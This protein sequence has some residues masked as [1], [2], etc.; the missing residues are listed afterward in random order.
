[1][2][3]RVNQMQPHAACRAASTGAATGDQLKGL[4]KILPRGLPFAHHGVKP[5][6]RQQR[7]SDETDVVCPLYRL[8]RQLDVLACGGDPVRRGRITQDRAKQRYPAKGDVIEADREGPRLRPAHPPQGLLRTRFNSG[9]CLEEISAVD[10]C[11]G[12]YGPAPPRRAFSLLK[13]EVAL[14]TEQLFRSGAKFGWWLRLH[15]RPG[16]PLQ[17]LDRCI[18]TIPH[19]EP[20]VGIR[21]G[22]EAEFVSGPPV[23]LL[24]AEAT[25]APEQ[26]P[27]KTHLQSVRV[28]T[29]KELE[30]NTCMVVRLDQAVA[31][32]HNDGK[33]FAVENRC[34]HMGFPLHRG[35]VA[36]GILT[37]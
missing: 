19:I 4:V 35:S 5:R 12:S 16:P 26:N 6:R 21:P 30:V 1:M 18:A 20:L 13:Q 2:Q 10:A 24:P 8:E 14:T 28:G 31:V 11:N 9:K 29:L 32:F 36:D 15:K 33:V 25:K 27:M 3:Q 34:P 17:L 23:R 7:V 37:C 22:E